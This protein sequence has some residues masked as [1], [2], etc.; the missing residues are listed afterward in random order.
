MCD[1]LDDTIDQ[2]YSLQSGVAKA[3]SQI[4]YNTLDYRTFYESLL[5]VTSFENRIYQNLTQAQL[6]NLDNEMCHLANTLEREMGI[7]RE[8]DY[9]K[10]LKR[11]RQD[12]MVITNEAA[13]AKDFHLSFI[14]KNE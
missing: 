12:S 14:K 11:Y 8:T 1:P 6:V 3:V 13:E 9:D 10:L 4:D 7:K 2:F 5:Y